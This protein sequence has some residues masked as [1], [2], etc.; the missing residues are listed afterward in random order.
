M[1]NCIIKTISFQWLLLM[2]LSFFIKTLKADDDF[3]YVRIEP[4]ITTNYLKKSH[5]KLGFIQLTA[6]LRV[7]GKE[8]ERK[9]LIHMP[10]VR[11]FII[12]FLNFSDEQAI[13]D[14]KNRQKLRISLSTGIQQMLT[15]QTGEPLIEEL[16]ITQ[17]MWN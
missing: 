6:E 3:T 4:I 1:K 13:K 14:V 9:L 7:N 2:L 8:K 17:F 16:V 12:E 15:D 5:K 10:L 11:E